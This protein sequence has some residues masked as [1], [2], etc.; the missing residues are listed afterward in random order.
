MQ[1]SVKKQKY[2]RKKIWSLALFLLLGLCLACPLTVRAAWMP[3][4]DPAI[5]RVLDTIYEMIQGMIM[6]TLKQQAAQMLNQQMNSLIGG[7]Q[8]GQAMFITNWQ[9]YLVAQPTNRT[10]N[11]MNDYISQMTMGRGSMTGYSAEG[12][13]GNYVSS[14]QNSA[15]GVLDQSVPKVTFE[16]N[17]SQMFDAGNFKGLNQYLS[18]INNPWG[19]NQMVTAEYQRKLEENRLIAESKAKANLGFIGQEDAQGNTLYP[20]SLA[21]QNMANVQDLG[22]KIIAGAENIPEVI[23]AVVSQ[24]ITR[25][26]QQG[27]TQVQMKVNS[28][29][30]QSS[31]KMQQ[32]IQSSGPKGRF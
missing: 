8:G 4:V 11:Y 24:M 5:Q 30:N 10:I 28:E 23:T 19:F 32:S 6:G 31:Q 15:M 12:F 13:F 17:P 14:L 18:G 27:F 7:G 29:V 21:M 20:G 25:A 1:I 22:N 2:I 3:G 26:M 16:M 9:D